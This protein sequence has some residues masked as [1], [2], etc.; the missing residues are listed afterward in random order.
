MSLLILLIER[1]IYIQIINGK[2]THTEKDTQVYVYYLNQLHH[3]LSN[4][5]DEV[6]IRESRHL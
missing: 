4:M 6:E 1:D 2:Y 5:T 3:P